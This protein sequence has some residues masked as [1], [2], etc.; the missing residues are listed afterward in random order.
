[1][2]E[3]KERMEAKEG[4]LRRKRLERWGVFRCALPRDRLLRSFGRTR[5]KV[6]FGYNDDSPLPDA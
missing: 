6:R 2:S 1:M 5:S 4:K 3:G